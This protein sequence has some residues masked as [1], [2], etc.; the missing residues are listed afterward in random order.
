MNNFYHGSDNALNAYGG[1]NHGSG[2]FTPKRH[3][4]VGNF[5]HHARSYEHNSYDCHEGNRLGARMRYNDTSSK[6]VPRYKVKNG[7]NYMKMDERFH[8]RRG[9]FDRCHVSY[10]HYKHSY[11]SENMY[12]EHNDSYSYGGYIVEEVLKLWE[13]HQDLLVTTI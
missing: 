13:L 7:G 1:N 3:I 9:N 2:N 5:S 10:D 12:N 6:G 4:G 11:G 8:K